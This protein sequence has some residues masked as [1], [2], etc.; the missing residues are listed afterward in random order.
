MRGYVARQGAQLVTDLHDTRIRTDG[1]AQALE[2]SRYSSFLSGDTPPDAAF[3]VSVLF[4]GDLDLEDIF[5][6]HISQYPVVFGCVAWVTSMSILAMLSTRRVVS[7]IVQK[8]DFLRPD[9][10]RPTNW[11]NNL[12]NAYDS[13]PRRLDLSDDVFNGTCVAGMNYLSD[14]RPVDPVRCVG[15]R[16]NGT[17]SPNMHHKFLVLCR[18]DHDEYTPEM[19]LTG[20][21]NFTENSNRSFENIVMIRSKDCA[22]AY[23]QEY[24]QMLAISEPLDWESEW[25]CPEW[26]IGT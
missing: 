7:L 17:V 16:R 3:D 8:E 12:R 26:R 25:V 14:E 10:G 1:I 20:S 19:V 11:K 4:G 2:H 6:S 24:C 5:C 23:F 15:L 13:L 22:A 9:I 18:A 21:Y